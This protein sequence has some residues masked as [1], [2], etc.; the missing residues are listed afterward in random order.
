MR[1]PWQKKVRVGHNQRE[2]SRETAKNIATGKQKLRAWFFGGGYKQAI[3]A[4]VLAVLAI[5]AVQAWNNLRPLDYFTLK[6]IQVVGNQKLDADS[7]VSMTGLRMGMPMPQVNA[8]SVLAALLLQPK[9]QKGTWVE[10]SVLSGRVTVHVQET[11]PLFKTLEPGGV[12]KVYSDKGLPFKAPHTSATPLPVVSALQ[13][14]ADFF[15]ALGFLNE[16][17]ERDPGLYKKI[18]QVAAS[19]Q[20]GQVEVVF[21]NAPQVVL[22][23]SQGRD[24]SVYRNYRLL[25]S[26]DEPHLANVRKIDM[27]FPHFAY[28]LSG[29]DT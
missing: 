1:F 12:W 8:D 25:M 5:V 10:K 14:S 16:I 20:A 3:L 4:G 29:G 24:A 17:R 26:A 6:S 18:S 23:A 15:T 9:I 7:I 11:T 19:A 2:K 13:S 28:T 21:S 22:F 27:R